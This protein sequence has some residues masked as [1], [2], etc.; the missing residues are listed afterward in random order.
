[1]GVSEF[2]LAGGGACAGTGRAGAGD[3]AAAL[4]PVA[5]PVVTSGGAL[6]VAPE[7]EE[8]DFCCDAEGCCAKAQLAASAT[9]KTESK[10]E[11]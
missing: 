1:M 11:K 8:A 3:G 9:T 2:I 5:A 4:V 7:E 10:Y 6:D